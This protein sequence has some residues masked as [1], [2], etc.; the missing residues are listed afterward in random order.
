M[1]RVGL[2]NTGKA[3]KHLISGASYFF[4]SHGGWDPES[5][6]PYQQAARERL[7]LIVTQSNESQ[8]ISMLA[9]TRIDSDRTRVAQIARQSTVLSSLSSETR[10]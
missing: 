4:V 5:G 9:Q 6:Q 1:L 2:R 10:N 7:S 3:T 8:N